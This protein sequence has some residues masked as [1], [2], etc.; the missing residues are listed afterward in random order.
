MDNL[1][2]IK[3]SIIID[4][5]NNNIIELW[6]K[7]KGVNKFKSS[8]DFFTKLNLNIYGRSIFVMKNKDNNFISSID[9][10]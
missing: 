1:D 3:N 2:N 8:F 7:D 10:V 6:G 9:S 4:N 5:F